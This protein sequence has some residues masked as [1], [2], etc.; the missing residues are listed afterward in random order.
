MKLQHILDTSANFRHFTN[1]GKIKSPNF[2]WIL[3]IPAG[4]VTK[5]W[6]ENRFTGYRGWR[7][8]HGTKKTFPHGTRTDASRHG[9]VWGDL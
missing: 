6:E 9:R 4:C 1:L 7:K 8:K 3:D 2:C 5:V